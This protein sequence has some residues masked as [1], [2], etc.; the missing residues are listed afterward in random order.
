MNDQERQDA[1]IKYIKERTRPLIK[2]DFVNGTSQ[3][4]IDAVNAMEK[5]IDISA[6]SEDYQQKIRNFYRFAPVNIG[7]PN[8]GISGGRSDWK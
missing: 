7:S 5:R 4:E 2:N 6:F 3:L 1:E 8:G